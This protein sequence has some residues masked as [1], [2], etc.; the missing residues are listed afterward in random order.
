MSLGD[1]LALGGLLIFGFWTSLGCSLTLDIFDRSHS[2]KSSNQNSGSPVAQIDLGWGAYSN[3]TQVN[4]TV[5]GQNVVA[6]RFKLGLASLTDCLASTGYSQDAKP[7]SENLSAEF[8]QL[9]DG[10]MRLC[11][12]GRAST[13]EEQLPQAATI[14]SW[15]K[16]TVAP[17]ATVDNAD[18]SFIDETTETNYLIKGTCEPGAGVVEISGAI[19]MN[20]L[21][22]N[23]FWELS[24]DVSSYPDGPLMVSVHQL[25]LAGNTS[26]VIDRNF[27]KDAAVPSVVIFSKN[28]D[29]IVEGNVTSSVDLKLSSPR[30]YDTRVYYLVDGAA[31]TGGRTNLVDGFVTIPAGQIS[32][33]I[34]YQ[35]IGNSVIDGKQ[36]LR[37]GLYSTDR[38]K[39]QIGERGIFYQDIM[40]DDGAPNPTVISVASSF[41]NTCVILS[42]GGLRCWG[43]SSYGQ[44][45]NG[46]TTGSLQPVTIDSGTS[47]AMIS[48]G[49]GPHTCGIT[50][51]GILRCWGWGSGG[52][53][54]IGS[55]SQQ[56]SPVTA[57]GGTNYKTVVVGGAGTCG[58][59]TSDV[60]KCWGYNSWGDLGDG[61]KTQ[62]NSPVVINSGTAYRRIAKA[63]YHACGITLAGVL[64]CWGHNSD[65]QL[66]D[67]TTSERL[68]PTIIDAGTSYSEVATGNDHSCAI[69]SAGRVKCWGSNFD[70]QLGDGTLV[71]KT[72][73][74]LVD[75]GELYVK[76]SIGDN[77]R[78]TCGIT[79]DGR[80]KCWGSGVT[81]NGQISNVPI[82]LD[83]GVHYQ[84]ISGPW[85]PCGLTT[86]GQVKCWGNNG[87]GMIDPTKTGLHTTPLLVNTR[88][89]VTS[90]S[91]NGKTVCVQKTD[92]TMGCLGH[93]A[94]GQIGDGTQFFRPFLTT[95]IKA[96]IYQTYDVGG[97]HTCGIT[98]DGVLQCWGNNLVKQLGTANGLSSL[99]PT[100]IDAGT[101][102]ARVS[103]G[104]FTTCGITSGGVLKCWGNNDVGQI[105]DGTTTQRSVPT[106]VDP[107]VEYSRVAVG[108]H[109][110]CGITI[111][112]VLKCWG[113]NTFG[114]L[115]I[116]STSPSL[117]PVVVDAGT[118]YTDIAL[119]KS[120][121]DRESVCAITTNNKLKCWG[122]NADGNIGDGTTN[123]RN[124]PV[125]VDAA[126]SYKKIS[127]GDSTCGITLG[128]FLRCWGSYPI[129]NGTSTDANLPVMIDGGTLYADVSAGE[130]SVCAV[131]TLG[132]LKCWGRQNSSMVLPNSYI[133]MG[134]EIIFGPFN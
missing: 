56:N 29:L 49:G 11:L 86:T 40:D 19:N 132:A 112:G 102:Y 94:F 101:S 46:T 24:T 89:A 129:G 95:I 75:A 68:V 105:G 76:I 107:G 134:P 55:T 121:I 3:A 82:E 125:A 98:D 114:E 80:L 100:P 131:T 54:G 30:I 70:G 39:V 36:R 87:G 31:I 27:Y 5:V 78:G 85:Q 126:Q 10:P 79:V 4:K 48:L 122:Y 120:S 65:G 111:G 77:A 12:L 6:Y 14:Y 44:L 99:I 91:N 18:L 23:G 73:P 81:I 108:S 110:A 97:A 33:S 13:G 64:K 103:S 35:L 118:A 21:C 16:D 1:R 26:A 127:V 123:Q 43:T 133:P 61:T 38:E 15:I 8:Q 113:D 22:A 71:D 124:S 9:P 57:D 119:S 58:I 17:N 115:G 84:M 47:Y 50:T 109:S 104:L 92:Q 42:S 60:L 2:T 83:E 45:G 117:L 63:V 106:V 51:S 37:I 20:S 34:S 128:G 90:V 72:T 25:D 116:G 62:R 74:T 32:A 93:N 88:G 7:I 130:R 53:L 52:Q 96:G 67:G 69:T 28:S 66:G 59:T 41:S